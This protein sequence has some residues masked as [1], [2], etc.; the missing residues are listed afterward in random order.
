MAPEPGKKQMLY[1]QKVDLGNEE[2]IIEAFQMIED[3]VGGANVLVNVVGIMAGD[4]ILGMAAFH[5]NRCM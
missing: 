2:E 4:S 1:C 5:T 3:T